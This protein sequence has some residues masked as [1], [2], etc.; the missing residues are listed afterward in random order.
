MSDILDASSTILSNNS[1]NKSAGVANSLFPQREPRK[2]LI[3]PLQSFILTSYQ[4]KGT[5]FF[6]SDLKLR[7]LLKITK[8]HP[9]IQPIIFA[10]S[11]SSPLSPCS[12]VKPFGFSQTNSAKLACKPFCRL[13][14]MLRFKLRHPPILIFFIVKK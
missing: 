3:S 12:S 7:L 5:D 11:G 8:Y 6:K 9:Q 1:G 14:C 13:L 2:I 10:R 4:M